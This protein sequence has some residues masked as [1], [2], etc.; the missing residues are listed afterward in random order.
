MI[1]IQVAAAAMGPAGVRVESFEDLIAMF[2]EAFGS[3]GRIVLCVGLWSTVFTTY[4]GSNTGYSL[5]AADLIVR[6]SGDDAPGAVARFQSRRRRVYRAFLIAFCVPPMGV[7]ITDWKPIPVILISSALS[8]ATLP[9]VVII[10]FMLTKDKKLM[11]D[12]ANG[13]W[14]NLALSSIIGLSA[15]VTWHAGLE[16]FD[17]FL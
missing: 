7:L 2:T 5:L 17:R 4:V 16:F 14:S 3:T 11:G 13:F 10:L 6:D 1:L 9:I 8:A 15:V 12:H